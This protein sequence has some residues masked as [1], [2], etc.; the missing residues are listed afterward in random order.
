MYLWYDTKNKK[1]CISDRYINCTVCDSHF[2]CT[3]SD[4]ED[5]EKYIKGNYIY[6]TGDIG[7][8]LVSLIPLDIKELKKQITDLCMPYIYKKINKEIDV[9]NWL[10]NF[11]NI[12][13]QISNYY[14]I[15]YSIS[16]LQSFYWR[17]I[18]ELEQ[19]RS[20]SKNKEIFKYNLKH[21]F[22]DFEYI[23]AYINSCIK[24]QTFY[25]VKKYDF[26][27]RYYFETE[28]RLSS[29][30]LD[31]IDL[32]YNIPRGNRAVDFNNP[33]EFIKDLNEKYQIKKK[34]QDERF[35]IYDKVYYIEHLSEFARVSL[36][37]ILKAEYKFKLCENC[38]IAFIPYNRS[39]T[40]YCDRPSP[41]DSYKTCKEYGAR[42]AYQNNLN[43]NESMK[44][45]RNIYM[46]KQMLSKRNPDIE[47]YQ[48]DFQN[49]KT[50]SKKWKNNIKLGLNTEDEY[51]SWLKDLR[52]KDN[53]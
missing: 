32:N 33:N 28:E 20:I 16:P 47:S 34:E 22:L 12:K 39:D 15:F 26:A 4:C 14:D 41:Q 52:R 53:N 49:Y 48:K 44:L 18:Y 45:Y 13:N 46:Q 31:T 40:I 17:Y 2:S 6:H 11:S 1:E 29:W 27:D 43:S 7:S 35:K 36:H 5:Y 21:T 51:Y 19:Q 9:Y 42:K 25:D 38:G 37:E 8:A 10:D 3:S 30:E 24:D 23:I 50:Q